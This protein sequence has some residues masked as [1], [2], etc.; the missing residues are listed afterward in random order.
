MKGS[1]S[2]RDGSNIY[3]GTQ[4]RRQGVSVIVEGVQGV[5]KVRFKIVG[6]GGSEGSKMRVPRMQFQ[7]KKE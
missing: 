6:N 4:I 7:Q 3:S 1:R 5:A 2:A